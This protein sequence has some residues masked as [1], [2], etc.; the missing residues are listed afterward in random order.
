MK[1][2]DEAINGYLEIDSGTKELLVRE[3]E[4]TLEPFFSSLNS[5]S[6]VL[7][8]GCGTGLFTNVCSL[9][10]KIECVTGIDS[11]VKMITAAC[12][13]FHNSKT[14]FLNCDFVTHGFD[15][16]YDGLMMRAFIHLFPEDKIR[17]EILPKS[18]SI[19]KAGGAIHITTSLHNAFKAAYEQKSN[20]PNSIRYRVRFTE[21]RLLDLVCEHY[22][23]IDIRYTDEVMGG[24]KKWI[25][26]T[27]EKL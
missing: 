7:D 5:K 22:R 17:T 8:I 21:E 2:Y 15:D 14:T 3:A 26:V 4:F 6:T 9:N 25:T 16:Q 12:Q 1:A 11:S 23:V 10:K 13:A 19:L 20:N 27:G 18:T 24:D